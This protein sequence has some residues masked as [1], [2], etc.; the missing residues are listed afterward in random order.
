MFPQGS[1]EQDGVPRSRALARAPGA[2]FWLAPWEI[3]F[4]QDSIRHTFRGGASSSPSS[5]SDHDDAPM[6]ITDTLN[7]M[8]RGDL[9]KRDI[10]MMK[11]VCHEGCYYSVCNR[12]LAVYLLL[13]L[14]GRCKRLKANTTNNVTTNNNH[15]IGTNASYDTNTKTNTNN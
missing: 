13:H 1:A 15:S 7:Q 11:V 6:S 4:T 9:R 5:G 12:R 3:Y 2:Q 8:L 14:C 10:E